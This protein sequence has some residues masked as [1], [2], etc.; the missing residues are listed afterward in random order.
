MATA[1]EITKEINQRISVDIKH[2]KGVLPERYAIA[3]AGY[4]ASLYEWSFISQKDFAELDSL[5]PRVSEPDPVAEIFTGRD[6]DD[7]E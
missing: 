1:E 3:W 2:F 5:L 4:I 7:D 6:N